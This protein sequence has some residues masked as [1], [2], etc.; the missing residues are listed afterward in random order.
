MFAQ[1][2]AV[3]EIFYVQFA[4]I[5]LQV[6]IYFPT[7]PLILV[8]HI[9]CWFDQFSLE[10]VSILTLVFFHRFEG[11]LTDKPNSHPEG[12]STAATQIAR[13]MFG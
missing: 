6:S 5:L 2:F 9:I 10:L 11:R 1:L 12:D 13:T 8:L 4:H 3:L 7:I